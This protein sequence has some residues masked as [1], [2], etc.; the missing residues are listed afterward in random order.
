MKETD[1]SFFVK[2]KKVVGT[3][4]LPDSDTK[5]PVVLLIHGFTGN[6]H[7]SVSKSAPKGKFALLAS[8][9][10]EVGIASLRIDMRGSGQSAGSLENITAFTELVV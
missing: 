1:L 2:G 3:L 4:S 10:S 9:L 5:A 7:E 8:K 6:R